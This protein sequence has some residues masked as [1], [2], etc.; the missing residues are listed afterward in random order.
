M[1]YVLGS[2]LTPAELRENEQSIT[3]EVFAVMRPNFAAGIPETAEVQRES[4]TRTGV[5]GQ[6]FSAVVGRGLLGPIPA[7]AREVINPAAVAPMATPAA[8]LKTFRRVV[9][10][11]A[12]SLVISLFSILVSLRS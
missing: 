2:I 5:I 4:Y 12:N 11:T 6:Q 7:L 1:A 10:S 9:S 8:I 3:R